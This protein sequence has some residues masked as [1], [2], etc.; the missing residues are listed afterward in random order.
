MKA[1]KLIIKRNAR[2][3]DFETWDQTNNVRISYSK[4]ERAIKRALSDL[5]RIDRAEIKQRARANSLYYIL[6]NFKG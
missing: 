6:N 1:R 3:L 2:D 5:K 4:N